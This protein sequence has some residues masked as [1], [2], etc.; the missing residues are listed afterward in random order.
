MK[1]LNKIIF[2]GPHTNSSTTSLI[3][4]THTHNLNIFS[5]PYILFLFVPGQK[6]QSNL[7]PNIPILKDCV[8]PIHN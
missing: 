6:N 2:L 8:R 7:E 3:E 5:L 4:D 1:K